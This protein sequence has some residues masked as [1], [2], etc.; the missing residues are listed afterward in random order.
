L[1]LLLSGRAS[2]MTTSMPNRS[3][4]SRNSSA[5]FARCTTA[6]FFISRSESCHAN[7]ASSMRTATRRFF[8]SIVRLLP[9]P[10]ATYARTMPKEHKE[11][12]SRSGG[13]YWIGWVTDGVAGVTLPPW[14]RRG[15]FFAMPP[16]LSC[17]VLLPLRA[18]MACLWQAHRARAEPPA[19]LHLKQ[20]RSSIG[21]AEPKRAATPARKRAIRHS[22]GLTCPPKRPFIIPIHMLAIKSN[23]YTF[24]KNGIWYFSRRVPS[25]LRRHYRVDRIA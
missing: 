7:C 15:L 16:T 6:P 2:A 19:P 10:M 20:A 22:Y 21:P 9:L 23:Q 11:R 25:D 5:S 18:A 14:M 4:N 13:G 24:Q 8:S 1:S 17:R 12:R 3:T